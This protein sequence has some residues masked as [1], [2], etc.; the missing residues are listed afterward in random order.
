M[1]AAPAGGG[2]LLASATAA[3]IRASRREGD[4]VQE[5]ERALAEADARQARRERRRARIGYVLATLAAVA[6]FTDPVLSVDRRIAVGTALALFAL[7]VPF[8]I[9]ADWRRRIDWT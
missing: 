4:V 3:R 5:H 9:A 1:R 8:L 7:A 6:L 2:T